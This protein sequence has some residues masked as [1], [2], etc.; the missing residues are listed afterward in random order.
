MGKVKGFKGFDKEMKCQGFQ[1]EVGKTYEHAGEVKL[2]NRGFHFCKNPLD[3]SDYYNLFDSHYAEVE[4]EGV[5]D[6]KDKDSKRVAKK[7][8]I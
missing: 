7:T 1:F 4:A 8:T 3:T 2:C 6:Q 5:S